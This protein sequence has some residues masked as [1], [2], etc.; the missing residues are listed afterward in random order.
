MMWAV[1]SLALVSFVTV[2]TGF[3]FDCSD[4]GCSW[5][6]APRIIEDCAGHCQKKCQAGGSGDSGTGA[7]KKA[8]K[9]TDKPGQKTEKPTKATKGPKTDKPTQRPTEATKTSA[10][11]TT[12]AI[13]TTTT[14][15]CKFGSLCNLRPS[16][17]L[18]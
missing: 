10:E 16:C 7:T 6:G 11:K 5:C 17:Q 12:K 4:V 1:V 8:V 3:P 18:I 14:S 13:E 15:V 9:S 2:S